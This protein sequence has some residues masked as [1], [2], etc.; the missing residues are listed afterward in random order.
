MELIN[1]I[2]AIFDLKKLPTK[3]FLVFSIVSGFILFSDEDLLKKLNL[4][5]IDENYGTFIGLVFLLS[6]GLVIVNLI[7]WINKKLYFEYRFSKSKGELAKSLKMLDPHEKSVIREFSIRQQ[8]SVSMPI[9]DPVITG[10]IDKG[11][12]KFNKQFGDSM[13]TSMGKAPVSLGKY[14]EKLI[15]LE[16]IDLKNDLSESEK[17]EILNKRPH[18]VNRWS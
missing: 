4:A 11:I 7:I 1:E 14:A 13:I 8:S 15:R 10:L 17:E 18:W 9:D 5:K 12:L 2:K 16:D 3:F 6:S